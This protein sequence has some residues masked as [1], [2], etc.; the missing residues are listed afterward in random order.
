MKKIIRNMTKL[1]VF[2][3]CLFGFIQLG[4]SQKD[5]SKSAQKELAS[6]VFGTYPA[7]YDTY[8]R[9]GSSENENYGTET[10]LLIKNTTSLD[11]ARKVLLQFDLSTIDFGDVTINKALVRLFVTSNNSRPIKAIELGDDW[12]ESTVTWATVPES[13]KDV[14][15][16]IVDN[17]DTYFEWDVTSFVRQQL[18]GDKV[19]SLCMDDAEALKKTISFASKE[20][21]SNAPQL[22]LYSGDVEVPATPV[23]LIARASSSTTINL[24]WE[25]LATNEDGYLIERKQGDDAFAELVTLGY[26]ATSFRDAGLSADT[27]YTYRLSAINSAGQSDYSNEATATTQNGGYNDNPSG[28]IINSADY[29]Y[30]R[31]LAETSPMYAAMKASALSNNGTETADV[32]GAN[33]LAYILDPENRSKYVANIKDK[34]DNRI[35]TMS[36]GANASGS[37]VRSHELFFALLAIDVI[38]HDLDSLVFAR[39]DSILE[40][41]IMQLVIG[42]WDPHGWAMRMLY[43]KFAGDEPS[44]KSAKVEWEIGLSEHYMP[45][46][47]VSPAGNGYCVQRWNSIERTA[48]NTTPDIMEYM[49]YNEYYTNPGILGLKEYMYGYAVAPFGRILLYGDSRDT[50]AQKPWDISGNTVLSPHIISAARFSP[51]AYKYAMWVLREGAGLENPEPIGYLSNYLIMAGTAANNKPL[52]FDTDDAVLAPSRLFKNYGVLISDAQS[53]NALYA[54]MLN[55]TGNTEYHTNYETNALAMAGYGEILMRNSGYDGPNNDVTVDGVTATFDFIHSNSES[56][57]TL[58]VNGERHATQTGEGIIEG[59]VGAEIEYFRGSSSTAI[60]GH[61]LRDLMFMQPSNGANGYYVVMDHVTTDNA[62]DNVNVVWHP[63]SAKLQ[64]IDDNTEY[65][66]EIKMENGADGPRIYTGNEATLTTH[67]GTPPASVEI[68]RTANQARSGYAYAADYIYANYN[69]SNSRVDILTVFFPGDKSHEVGDMTRIETGDY[70]GAKITQG[71]IQDVALTSDGTA[72]GNYGDEVFQGEDII[73]RKSGDKLMSYFVKGVSFDDGAGT[74]CGFQ[75]EASVALFMKMSD[76]T[77]G[78]SGKIYSSGTQVTFYC[79]EI[80]SVQLDGSPAEIIEASPNWIKVQVPSGTFSLEISGNYT[81]LKALPSLENALITDFNYDP[82]NR[83]L[84]VVCPTLQDYTV[85][86]FD[87]SGSLMH[88]F[89]STN[90]SLTV[91]LNDIPLGMYMVRVGSKSQKDV[92]KIFIY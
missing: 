17:T 58:M 27:S 21:G 89:K 63:N 4:S 55:L 60:K 31:N 80:E 71:D 22:V 34:F 68:K 43:Y 33:A 35:T 39:Y 73:Y 74:R 14:S 64:Q 67:L 61:H 59:L 2:S 65:F 44:F 79:P 50:E 86:L 82:F 18:A 57:N 52:E 66:S 1:V 38:R 75:S 6:I 83:K 87:V 78:L 49:G 11:F 77:N 36:I 62:E 25:D 72:I 16:T 19:I 29:A 24:T 81:S 32:M 5:E 53:T 10:E 51:E 28:N 12:N 42:Q 56:S 70:T 40:N 20:L 41:K 84:T 37:S 23:S 26:G 8:V 13:G 48:K 7:T 15:Q 76:L 90:A 91:P 45:D 30:W 3:L 46:D 92:R 88:S 9:G 54:S 69:T 47:G 85:E